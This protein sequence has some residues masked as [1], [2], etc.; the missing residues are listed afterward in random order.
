VAAFGCELERR[1]A[2]WETICPKAP[3]DVGELLGN[4]QVP[5]SRE[6]SSGRVGELQR[7]GVHCLLAPI[8]TRGVR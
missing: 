5:Q 2:V 3:K 7:A 6:Q 8:R 1:A 4:G